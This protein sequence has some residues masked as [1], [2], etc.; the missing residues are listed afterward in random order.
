MGGEKMAPEKSPQE[1]EEKPKSKKS[2]IF[3]DP[4]VKVEE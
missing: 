1:K 2:R 3:K 4:Y